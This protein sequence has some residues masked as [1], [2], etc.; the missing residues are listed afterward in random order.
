[1]WSLSP[2][3][4]TL[5][6]TQLADDQSS[7]IHL[8]D[9]GGGAAK[10]FTFGPGDSLLPVWSPSSDRIVFTRDGVPEGPHLRSKSV[11]SET[12]SPLAS[13][14]L[15]FE[16]PHDWHGNVLLFAALTDTGAQN[17][18]QVA[19]DGS[20]APQVWLPSKFGFARAQFS[21]DGRWVA[22]VSNETGD[23]EVHVRRFPEADHDVLISKAGGNRPRWRSDG[24]ALFYV[25]GNKLVEVELEI[26]DT[27][28]T[29]ADRN[30]FP[31]GDHCGYA[32]LP[33][34]KGFLLCRSIDP[35]SAELVVVI[36][37]AA[38]LRSQ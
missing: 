13:V 4:R 14:K 15:A 34:T 28:R 25:E 20:R 29:L 9:L 23:P 8:L 27:V 12:D 6:F 37:W 17:L 5:A 10:R 24:R 19:T 22:Y 21:P 11:G 32:V 16:I 30:L 2:D 31:L 36:N 7:D 35:Q 26:G 38:S 1:M 3:A 33:S 18:W